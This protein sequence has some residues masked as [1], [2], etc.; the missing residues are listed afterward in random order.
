MD[1]QDLQ[2]AARRLEE[3]GLRG[4][5]GF[6]ERPA[7]V[8]VDVT[9]GFTDPALPLGAPADAEVEAIRRTIAAARGAGI[10]ILYTT[11]V[12]D[13]AAEVWAGKIP[14]HRTL[15]EG[16][17]SV[18]LDPR[19]DRR[20]D[21]PL[22]VKHLPSA[23][24]GTGLAERLRGRGVDTV[25][26]TG[27][28]TSGCVRATVVDGCSYGFRMIVPREAVGDRVAESHTVSLFD[29]DAKYGDVIDVAE[30]EAALSRVGG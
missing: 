7:L 27:F 4:R 26:V 9:R 15:A 18:E 10:P 1:Q 12:Y 29:I 28:T 20:D 30:V 13:P 11:C 24:F 23:F 25:I 14:S 19:L 2:G 8:V 3:R 21:E 6:G 16:S 17:E 22:I 5:V